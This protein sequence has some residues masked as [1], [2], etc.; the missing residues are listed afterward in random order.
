MVMN[1]EYLSH[2][3]GLD[4]IFSV[5]ENADTRKLHHSI[6]HCGIAKEGVI[7]FVYL[8]HQHTSLN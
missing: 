6:N 7:N 3:V 5:N 1:D 4:A 2:F 8:V